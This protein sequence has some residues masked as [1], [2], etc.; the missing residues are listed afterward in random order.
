MFFDRS[1][2]IVKQLSETKER[3][4][5][6]SG[7]TREFSLPQ[8]EAAT[9]ALAEF[10]PATSGDHQILAF[11]GGGT[12]TLTYLYTADLEPQY[13]Q[14]VI[15]GNRGYW[16]Y[17]AHRLA[18]PHHIFALPHRPSDDFIDSALHDES[19]GILPHQPESAYVHSHDYQARVME[20]ERATC[21][22]LNKKGI[23]VF[24]IRDAWVKKI[25]KV[26]AF[27][28]KI[29][30]EHAAIP[31][32]ANKVICATGAGPERGLEP[33][34]KSLLFASAKDEKDI[35]EVEDRVLTYTK[36]LSP[37][38]EKCKGKDVLIYGGGATAAWAM[39]VA[40]L[41]AKPVAWVG[42]S[43]FGNAITAGPRVGAILE[44]SRSLQ[45]HGTIRDISYVKEG[46]KIVAEVA[47]V[48][49]DIQRFIFDYLF[50]CIGQ[51]PYEPN[52]SGLPEV[53]SPVLRSELIPHLDKDR[54][55]GTDQPCMLGWISRDGDFMVSGAAQGTFYDKDRQIVRPLS[56]SSFL[57]R[58]AQVL[59]TIGGVVAEICATTGYMNVIQDDK[60]GKVALK[61]LNIHVMNAT[62]L[63]A[64]F[65]GLYPKAAASQVNNAIKA[66]LPLRVKTEF[67][68]S[69]ER[70][71][72]F[73]RIHFENTAELKRE[74][75]MDASPF[76]EVEASGDSE[77]L[78]E[79]S[80]PKN[81][82]LRLFDI[83]RSDDVGSLALVSEAMV[84]PVASSEQ[85]SRVAEIMLGSASA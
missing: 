85:S 32:F 79:L 18:Q 39:E 56:I 48:K 41:V 8:N 22:A 12:A 55:T 67:G 33:Q 11:V 20:L 26:T 7:A 40:A 59:I 3:A 17:S 61:N 10:Y 64:Y 27:N 73:M 77:S 46:G 54:M 74:V 51:E 4:S 60:T 37:V 34:L 23:D 44:G 45:V 83:D 78:P 47:T 24:I 68:L 21:A 70:L 14:V 82:R 35:A 81:Y 49:G 80:S 62:Q 28:F 6:S 52:A 65:T 30:I 31:V 25:D 71:S 50:N 69:S 15:F 38:V 36:I 72:E 57:P 19:Q 5:R 43:G 29:E 63:A 53:I 75:L 76:T 9:K 2:A 58:S 1:K 84:S 13:T 42:R 16:N 66:Y